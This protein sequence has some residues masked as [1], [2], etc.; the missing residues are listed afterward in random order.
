MPPK[1]IVLATTNDKFLLAIIE[2]LGGI[3]G[4]K[5]DVIGEKMGG[6]KRRTMHCARRS[7]ASRT[8]SRRS[9][10]LELE[11]ATLMHL[12]SSLLLLRLSL[13]LK[14]ARLRRRKM[15]MKRLRMARSRG[16]LEYR[17]SSRVFWG[18]VEITHFL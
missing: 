8:R 17:S 6:E 9:R 16:G 12:L 15:K 2:S 11:L 18:I 10:L 4:I 14:S 5:W 3:N 7:S 13:R 1:Q